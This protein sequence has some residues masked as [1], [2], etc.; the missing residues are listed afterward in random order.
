MYSTYGINKVDIINV[1]IYCTKG[2]S[3][4]FYNLSQ[5]NSIKKKKM[6]ISCLLMFLCNYLQLIMVFIFYLIVF[7]YIFSSIELPTL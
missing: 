6:F 2:I 5:F 1:N 4:F 3:E 7:L